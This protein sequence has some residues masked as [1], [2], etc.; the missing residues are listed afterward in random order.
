M[1]WDR[2]LKSW[3]PKSSNKQQADDDS[4]LYEVMGE[5]AKK[6]DLFDKPQLACVIRE[7]RN[8]A[9]CSEAGRRLFANSRLLK[10]SN[11]DADRVRKY[12]AS[13]GLDWKQVSGK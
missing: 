7:C 6:L 9:S 3:A 1:E 11:N 12:L 5:Q 8:S 13:F 4:L 10:K 2:L